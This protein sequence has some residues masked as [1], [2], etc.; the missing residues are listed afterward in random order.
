MPPQFYRIKK[1]KVAIKNEKSKIVEYQHT[2]DEV[3]LEA[4]I[5]EYKALICHLA[6]QY[7]HL[8]S[9]LELNDLISEGLMLS[10]IHI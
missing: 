1:C 8:F 4:M 5:V 2:L 3:I 10:L 6:N 9:Y 7:L